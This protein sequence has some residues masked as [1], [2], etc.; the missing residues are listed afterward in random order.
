MHLSTHFIQL[1]SLSAIALFS[2]QVTAQDA[3]VTCEDGDSTVS[4]PYGYL[5]DNSSIPE[6]SVSCNVTIDNDATTVT[7]DSGNVIGSTSFN[8]TADGTP[9]NSPFGLVV[10]DSPNNQSVSSV[11]PHSDWRL[12]GCNGSTAEPQSVL[13]YCSKAMDD[14]TSGCSHVFIG[15]AEHTIVQMPY[16]CG[17]S[18][19]ARIKSL[20]VHSH[21]AIRRAYIEGKPAS[22]PV[23]QLDWDYD[24]DAIPDDNG[25]INMRV[26]ASNMPGYWDNIVESPPERKRW[27]K[28]REMKREMRRRDVEQPKEEFIPLIVGLVGWVYAADDGSPKKY[29]KYDSTKFSVSNSISL[30]D[31]TGN[32]TAGASFD[33]T[34]TGSADFNVRYGY[35]LEAVIKPTPSVTAAYVYLSSNAL[36][37]LKIKI[38]GEAHAAYNSDKLTI[39]K[40]GVPGLDYQPLVTNSIGPSLLVQGYVAG[41]LE[42]KGSFETTFQYDLPLADFAFGKSKDDMPPKPASGVARPSA[43]ATP[44]IDYSVSLT[45]D[46]SVHLN[47]RLQ[48]GISILNGKLIDAQAYIGADVS[49]G[50][51]ASASTGS[52]DPGTVCIKPYIGV[53]FDGGLTGK[54]VFWEAK[55]QS[56]PIWSDKFYVPKDGFCAKNSRRSIGTEHFTS[57]DYETWGIEGNHDGDNVVEQR[58]VPMSSRIV[59]P[60]L[61]L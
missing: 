14:P 17:K 37:T 19:Y 6:G 38:S 53:A 27:L 24:F 43:N 22:E 15:Q 13:A 12:V 36:T 30:G 4:V 47:P 44:D 52:N 34:L 40:V 58:S 50:I 61:A 42:L 55:E 46:L 5:F 33:I 56:W 25:Q 39:G 21:P 49:G 3:A 57:D 45:G 32:S 18:P 31:T 23:Y 7:D 59:R 54:L 51:E 10:I 48:M 41:T 11:A 60:G 26:D 1:L 28:E 20:Q 8:G 9:E 2:H 16:G 29:D 35:Y